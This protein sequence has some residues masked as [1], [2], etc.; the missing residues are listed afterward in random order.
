MSNHKKE[1]L[2]LFKPV[3]QLWKNLG[4]IHYLLNILSPTKFKI[5]NWL[6]LGYVLQEEALTV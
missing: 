2:Y 6:I 5:V 3:L 1:S 4:Q